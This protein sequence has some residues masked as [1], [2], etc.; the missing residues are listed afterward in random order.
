VFGYSATPTYDVFT[1]RA[2]SATLS[3]SY[4]DDDLL[5]AFGIFVPDRELFND[6]QTTHT[7]FDTVPRMESESESEFLTS[8]PSQAPSAEEG[9]VAMGASADARAPRGSSAHPA[10]TGW[11]LR[12]HRRRRPLLRI[13]VRHH[14]T[15]HSDK[16]KTLLDTHRVGELIATGAGYSSDSSYGGDRS[17]PSHLAFAREAASRAPAPDDRLFVARISWPFRP[18]I[19]GTVIAK[20]ATNSTSSKSNNPPGDSPSRRVTFNV[21]VVGCIPVFFEHAATGAHYDWPLLRERQHS[22]HAG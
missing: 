12:R 2:R 15:T 13:G 22:G 7:S 16:D 8:L 21:I 10:L 1:T 17:A 20:C 9:M 11:P 6:K 14:V 5:G 4:D 19:W 18:N 3:P